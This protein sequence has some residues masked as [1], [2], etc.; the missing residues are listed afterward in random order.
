MRTIIWCIVAIT[1]W[2]T[3]T[4]Y[5]QS[6]NAV[7]PQRTRILFLLDASGSMRQKW[8]DKTKF[9]IAKEVLVKLIDSVEQKKERVEFALRLFGSEYPR[10]KKNCT[11]TKLLVSFSKNNAQRIKEELRKITPKGMTPISYAISQCTNDFSSDENAINSIVLITD[12][13]ENC[14]MNLCQIASEL[15]R[16]RLVI[17][18]FIIGLNL[19]DKM[20]KEFTCL[21][22]VSNSSNEREFERNTR[23]VVEKTLNKTTLQINLLDRNAQPTV[24]NVPFSLLDHFS[25]KALYHFIHRQKSAQEPDT[26]VIPPI[27]AY[28]LL[29]HTSPPIKISKITLTPGTHNIVAADVWL[30]EL[31]YA[32][33]VPDEV[34]VVVRDRNQNLFLQNTNDTE[35]YLSGVYDVELTTLPITADFRQDLKKNNKK[36]N[37]LDG[38]G[39][40]LLSAVEES[41]IHIIELKKGE[42][43]IAHFSFIGTKQLKMQPGKYLMIYKP[44]KSNKSESTKSV[45]FESESGKQISIALR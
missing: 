22:S 24:T 28:D 42:K 34:L 16:K 25:G 43:R 11:D 36:E 12:G 15:M 9:D 45:F 14:H 30:S 1:V 4:L 10:E 20:Q 32:G 31:K 13:E 2:W 39:T 37:K 41:V 38:F 27:G 23:V 21:G 33:S 44:V 26:L 17:Q 29:I 8:S 7:S 5:A 3:A 19:S 40:I 6:S 35:S 18:P